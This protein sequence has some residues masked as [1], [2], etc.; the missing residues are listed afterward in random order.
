MNPERSKKERAT[1]FKLIYLLLLLAG[2]GSALLLSP[3]KAALG[4]CGND[5]VDK[6]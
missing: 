3:V 2:A 5:V 1:R 4:T 6:F